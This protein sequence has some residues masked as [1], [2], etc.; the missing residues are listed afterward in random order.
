MKVTVQDFESAVT[1]FVSELCDTAPN[2]AQKFLLGAKFCGKRPELHNYLL[3][4]ADKDGILD[5][6]TIR[7]EIDFGLKMAGGDF[8]LSTDFGIFQYAGVPSLKMNLTK[9][10]AD[11]FFTQTVPSVCK[12][13]EA[14]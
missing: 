13:V 8:D 11:K 12:D 5:V 1:F 10:D 7:E 2:K 4:R 6:D 14:K 9:L 3:A